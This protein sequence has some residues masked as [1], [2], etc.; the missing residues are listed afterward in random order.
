MLHQS[1]KL[2]AFLSGL[3]V[4]FPAISAGSQTIDGSLIV[5]K[6]RAESGRPLP[7]VIVELQTGNGA[8]VTLAVTT[9]EGD[10][11]FSG[12]T[13]ASFMIVVNDPGY[14]PV[15]ERVELTRSGNARPGES[16]RVDII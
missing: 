8:P 9:N 2:S 3:L 16:V 5:G 1:Q 7:N 13:G 6:V 14:L 12:L 4:L 11:A 10:F 15:S